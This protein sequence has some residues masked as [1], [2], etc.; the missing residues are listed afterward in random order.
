MLMKSVILLKTLIS[1]QC[2]YSL[3]SFVSTVLQS[4][5]CQLNVLT[6]FKEAETS[7]LVTKSDPNPNPDPKPWSGTSLSKHNFAV[8]GVQRIS[9]SPPLLYLLS[10]SLSTPPY[11]AHISHSISLSLS[12]YHQRGRCDCAVYWEERPLLSDKSIEK[13]KDRNMNGDSWREIF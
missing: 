12:L 6:E 1:K 8:V 2:F 5:I 11:H 9:L 3:W 4:D 10:L 7:I 13:Y